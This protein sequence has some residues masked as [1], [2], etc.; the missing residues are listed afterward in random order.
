MN[1]TALW[2]KKYILQNSPDNLYYYSACLAKTYMVLSGGFSV[3]KETWGFSPNI[4][5]F[6]L[7]LSPVFSVKKVENKA[8]AFNNTFRSEVVGI[9]SSI[10]MILIIFHSWQNNDSALIRIMDLENFKVI[11]PIIQ[12]YLFITNHRDSPSRGKCFV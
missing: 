10:P 2:E 4:Y 8:L 6:D 12:G 1:F 7:N 5:V 11:S 9:I 3:I